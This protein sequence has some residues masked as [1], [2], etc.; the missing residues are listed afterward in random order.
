LYRRLA[1]RDRGGPPGWT[2]EQLQRIRGSIV[3]RALRPGL[4]PVLRLTGLSQQEMLVE[5][6]AA[7]QSMS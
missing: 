3:D 5:V 6:L 2:V 7:V 4:G 1:E